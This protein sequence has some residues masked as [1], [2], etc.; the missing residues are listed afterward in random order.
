MRASNVRVAKCVTKPWCMTALIICRYLLQHHAAKENTVLHG[1]LDY[2]ERGP[3]LPEHPRLLPTGRLRRES[4]A[5][6]FHSPV[7]DNVFPAHKWDN[8]ADV[9][10]CALVGKI[11]AV[12]NVHGRGFRSADDPSAQCT[13]QEAVYAQDGALGTSVFHSRVSKSIV[14][15]HTGRA[16]RGIPEEEEEKEASEPEPGPA[17]HAEGRE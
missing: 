7:A 6:H 4:S 16:E 13:P 10:S 11:S 17:G 12:H 8:T 14:H 1:Q 2:P 15:E 5:H 3:Q 9:A